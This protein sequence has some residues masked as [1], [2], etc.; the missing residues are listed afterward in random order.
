MFNRW[1]MGAGLAS[2]LAVGVPAAP[3][4]AHDKDQSGAGRGG[5]GIQGA[6]SNRIE[7]TIAHVRPADGVLTLRVQ[8]GRSVRLHGTPEQLQDLAPGS[9]GAFRYQNYGSALWLQ[10]EAGLGGSGQGGT[11]SAGAAGTF[12]GTVQ[13]I[14]GAEGRVTISEHTY[15][16]HPALLSQIRTGDF[17]AA[18]CECFRNKKWLRSIEKTSAPSAAPEEG[19][20]G[21]GG[22]GGGGGGGGGAY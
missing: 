16:T 1:V 2:L 21:T 8:D 22:M 5:T 17:V 12:N 20:G 6:P 9:R 15:R 3:A 7:G 14:D 11:G 13:S 19:V 18:S 10:P 4:N